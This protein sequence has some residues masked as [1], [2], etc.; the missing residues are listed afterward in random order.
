[1]VALLGQEAVQKRMFEK[2]NNGLHGSVL[3]LGLVMAACSSAPTGPAKGSPAWYWQAAGETYGA[4]DFLKANNHLDSL[5]KPGSEYAVRAQPWRMILSGGL[6]TGYMELADT[7]EQGGRA[8]KGAA[9]NFRSHLNLYRKEAN[10]EALSFASSFIA[11]QKSN[12]DGNVPIA[13]SFPGGSSG[14]VAELNKL[15][16]G[17]VLSETEQTAVERRVLSR[18][19]VRSA[20]SAVGAPDNASKAQ[21]LFSGQSATVPKDTFV[22][23]MA[24]KLYELSKFYTPQK[25][26]QSERLNLFRDQALAAA[27]SVQQDEKSKKLVSDIEKEVKA[28]GKSIS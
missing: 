15:G 6:A 10:R 14:P 21:Q 9:A 3:C 23:A 11:F 25:F 1:M 17:I 12:P 26:D 20:S 7:M 13:F 19:L 5:V 2:K 27:K 18:A 4:G 28:K 8:N 24:A 16:Q 22:L